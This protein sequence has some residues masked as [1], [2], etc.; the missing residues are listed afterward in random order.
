MKRDNKLS[1]NFKRSEFMCPCGCGLVDVDFNLVD[2]LQS[3][4]NICTCIW[5]KA[6]IIVTSGYRCVDYNKRV[7]GAPN[8]KHLYG[9][10]ADIQ[11]RIPESPSE[12]TVFW[13]DAY[14]IVLPEV[15]A[16][17]ASCIESFRLGGIGVYQSH[18]HLDVRTN[19]PARWGK[20]WNRIHLRIG[21]ERS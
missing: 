12:Y 8:S 9:L 3:L 2:H 21:G 13:A 4:R 10:A 1:K 18:T 15:V 16:S 7:D 5:P 6:K 14:W 11:V 17:L 19:G 20:R